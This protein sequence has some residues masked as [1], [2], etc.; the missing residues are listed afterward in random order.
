M[1]GDRQNKNPRCPV[2]GQVTVEA[3]GISYR[4]AWQSRRS[5][6]ATCGSNKALGNRANASRPV[7]IQPSLLFAPH[8]QLSKAT[9]KV[10]ACFAPP[11]APSSSATHV[12]FAIYRTALEVV[13]CHRPLSIC[14]HWQPCHMRGRHLIGLY[15]RPP[16][17]AL[18]CCPSFHCAMMQFQ[19]SE[20]PRRL[21]HAP[22]NACFEDT[23]C[24][25]GVFARHRREG[26]QRVRRD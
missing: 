3:F 16:A 10:F 8:F 21:A 1:V 19:P 22:T 4:H 17:H 14:R 23:G 7:A 11:G 5:T 13:A 26:L 9:A 25:R 18:L 20:N 24:K 2:L 6:A 15:R 12:S